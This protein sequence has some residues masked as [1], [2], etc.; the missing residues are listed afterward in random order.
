MSAAMGKSADIAVIINAT[1]SAMQCNA[2]P[3]N[4]MG[5]P[6]VLWT[7]ESNDLEGARLGIAHTEF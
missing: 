2:T 6:F 3:C 1:R 5:K 4:T 7:K